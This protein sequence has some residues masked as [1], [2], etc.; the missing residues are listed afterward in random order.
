MPAFP[1]AIKAHAFRAASI[2]AALAVVWIGLW[3]AAGMT[4]ARSQGSDSP[5]PEA[6]QS[7][8]R[9]IGRMSDCYHPVN[10]GCVVDLLDPDFVER[11]GG[12]DKLVQTMISVMNEMSQ[13]GFDVRPEQTQFDKPGAITPFGSVLIAKTTTRVAA[14]VR[15]QAGTIVGT[16]LALSRDGGK[17]W[18]FIE[19]TKAT[20][21]EL[22]ARFSGLW[23]RL[24]IPD[25]RL[26][27]Q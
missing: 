6:Q 5:S 14:I 9:D 10:Q 7:L 20:R 19:A 1:F 13:H 12:R 18:R 16:M 11:G 8:D 25:T 22:E 26:V 2:R 3:S 17:S 27:P 4:D 24:A 23:D 15:G 21:P